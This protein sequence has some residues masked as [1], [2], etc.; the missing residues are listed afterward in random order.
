[1]CTTIIAAEGATADGSFLLARSADS[2]ALKAQHFVIHEA[3]DHPAG[4]LYRTADH[5]GATRF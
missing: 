2:S 4:A 3:A 5:C 1:M